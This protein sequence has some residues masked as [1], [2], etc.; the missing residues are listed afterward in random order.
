MVILK[1]EA[2]GQADGRPAR[3]EVSAR[4]PDGYLFTAI[5]VVATALQVLDGSIRKPGLWMMGQLAEPARLMRD[6]Q[7]MGVEVSEQLTLL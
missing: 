6:M 4:H 3:L 5:P 1:L 7:R 2:T